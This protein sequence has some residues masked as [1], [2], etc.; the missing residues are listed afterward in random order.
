MTAP[1]DLSALWMHEWARA[2]W[3]R[4]A[5]LD[6]LARGGLAALL[7]GAGLARSSG[8]AHAADD[9]TV[10]IGYLPITDATALL[11]AHAKGYFEEAGLKVAE[12]TPVRSWSRGSL[13]ASSTSRTCSS[14]SRSGCATTTASR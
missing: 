3:T 2:D 9:D 6:A 12:P 4:R 13:P 14:P 7:G 10:R 5:T 11:V 8:A 1:D